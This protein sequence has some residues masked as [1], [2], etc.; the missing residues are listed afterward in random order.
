M[1][2]WTGEQLKQSEKVIITRARYNEL[3]M[4]NTT[5]VFLKTQ[6]YILQKEIEKLQELLKK[7]K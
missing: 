1:D 6:N 7:V 3:E 4:Y 5:N 2:D